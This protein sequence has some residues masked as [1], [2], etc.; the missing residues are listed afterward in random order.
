MNQLKLKDVTKY[1]EENIGTFHQKRID[2]LKKLELKSVLKRKNPYLFK[3]KHLLTAE[4]IIRKLTDAF[5]S[6]N[7]ET[8]FGVRLA[9]LKSL[10][11]FP[12]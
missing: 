9:V 2:G 11:I 4:E 10:F 8:L 1:V 12:I 7:E 6:S 5:I 3:A